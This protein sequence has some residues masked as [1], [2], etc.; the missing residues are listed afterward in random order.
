MRHILDCSKEDKMQKRISWDDSYCGIK[1]V[2][3]PSPGIKTVK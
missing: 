2:L 3:Y 1:T